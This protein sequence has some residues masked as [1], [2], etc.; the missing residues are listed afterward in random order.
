[1]ECKLKNK[2]AF[3]NVPGDGVGPQVNGVLVVAKIMILNG[4]KGS[5]GACKN[6]CSIGNGRRD[7]TPVLGCLADSCPIKKEGEKTISG[8]TC[9]NYVFGGKFSTADE[10][11]PFVKNMNVS[12]L[13]ALKASE[14]PAAIMEEPS[15]SVSAG[16]GGC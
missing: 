15:D 3:P 7:G 2:S 4:M 9:D 12:S 16:H 5:T 10:A 6:L 14:R 13:I 8:R 11:V 1:M